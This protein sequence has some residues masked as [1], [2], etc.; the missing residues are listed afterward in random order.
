MYYSGPIRNAGGTAAAWSVVI[1]DYLRKKFNFKEYDPTEKEVKR[2]HAELEDYHEFIT[3]LQYFPSKEECEFLMQNLPVE[4]SGDPSEKYE[5]SNINYKD[6]PRV[7]TNVL[8]SGYC[9]MHSSCIP[10]K[11]PKLWAKLSKYIKELDMEQWS[12]LEEFLKVQKQ[13]KAE[14]KGDKKE[15]MNMREQ[16]YMSVQD[17]KGDRLTVEDFINKYRRDDNESQ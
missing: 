10:L 3:N 16:I 12:F 11:A 1:A 2:C 8:R 7:N 6:L 17:G 4:I 5:V 15:K 13:S 9:L 14:G